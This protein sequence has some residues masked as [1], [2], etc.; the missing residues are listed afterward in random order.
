VAYFKTQNYE[1][2]SV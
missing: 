1:N 2:L